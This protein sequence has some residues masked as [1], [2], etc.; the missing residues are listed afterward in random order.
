MDTGSNTEAQRDPG[1]TGTIVGVVV[2]VLALL[3]AS[4][5]I[6]IV[7]IAVLRW[8]VGCDGFHSLFLTR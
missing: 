5:L 2:A 8:V 1:L 4:A 6:I 3:I 7:V